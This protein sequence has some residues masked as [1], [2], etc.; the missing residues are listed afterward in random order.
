MAKPSSDDRTPIEQRRLT[1]SVHRRV[2]RKK[3]AAGA[4]DRSVWFGLGM[5]GLVGWA[6]TIPT[7]AGIALG[8]WIDNTWP[9]PISWTLTLLFIG[10][11]V[12]CWNAWYWIGQ[13]SGRK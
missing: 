7:L 11:V 5:F 6:V 4:Q 12:G 8:W 2:R 10:A 9:G 3:Q 1:E 13:E